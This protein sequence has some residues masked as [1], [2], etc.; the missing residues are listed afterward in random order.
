VV[1]GADTASLA[2][3]EVKT[4]GGTNVLV[5]YGG[6]SAQKSGVIDTVTRSLESE[7]IG[8]SCVGGVQPN[9]LSQFAQKTVDDYKDKNIDFVLA[10]GGGSV[11]DTAKGVAHGLA[12]PTVPVWNFFTADAAVK[13][14]LPVGAI[15]TIAAAGSETSDSAVLTNQDAG[16]KRGLNTD[17][18]R[19]KFAI[20]DPT[21]TYSIPPRLTACGAVDILMHTLDRY[22]APNTG[23]DVTDELAEALMRVIIKYGK[24]AVEVPHDYKARA[25]LM[26]AGSLSHNGLMGLGQ[27]IDFSAHRLG[28]VFSAKYDSPHGESLSAVWPAWARFVYHK[29]VSRFAKY[30]RSVWG[31]TDSDDKTA[32]EAGIA[33][34]E[35]YFK[36]LDMPVTITELAGKK[37]ADDID[38]LVKL[39]TFNGTRIIGAFKVLSEEDITSIFQAAL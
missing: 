24:L 4:F 8:Y 34:T 37:V 22:F 15:L 14:S 20:M 3:K 31:V 10:V 26:W 6:G 33:A 39:C 35:N 11:I 25:E 21:L 30:A 27:G 38:K 18:N 1:F 5:L 13:T 9:P 23:N 17:F 28:V 36:S 16:E 7:G 29:D 19:P 12:E 2:G 32:A